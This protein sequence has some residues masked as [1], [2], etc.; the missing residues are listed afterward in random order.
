MS[1]SCQ[2]LN[3]QSLDD[4]SLNDRSFASHMMSRPFIISVGLHVAFTL[5]MV[6]GMPMLGR[7]LPEEM[8]LVRLEVVRTV[9]ETNLI[10]GDKPSTAKEEQKATVARKPPP[11]PPPP[12]PRPAAA[13]PAAPAPEPEPEAPAEDPAAEILPDSPTPK[14]K[15]AKVDLP[16]PKPKSKPVAKVAPKPKPKPVIKPVSKPKRPSR[17][18]PPAPKPAPRP[19]DTAK[20]APPQKSKANDAIASQLNKMV[21]DTKKRADAA[22]GVL[23]NLAEAKVAAKDAEQAR[24]TKERKVAADTV[25]KTLSAVAGNAVKAPPKKSIAPVGIDDVARIQQHVSKCWQ[26]PLGAAGNDTLIVDIFV[27]VNRD[28]EVLKADIEDKLRFNLDSY[29]KASAIAAQRAIVDC[30]PLPIPP[31]K[32]D[33][34]KEFTFEFNPKF[35]SR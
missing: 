35:I 3:D 28:G 14:P 4:Q 12:P 33:Q 7:D 18:A 34:L 26:P 5:L 24:K 8:P 9:P 2:S 17:P 30:S 19:V 23:Q 6:F 21:K 10:E 32:Y 31:Q 11:P 13:P 20:P 1:P 15:L 27:S 25:N 22:S 29:F 16:K